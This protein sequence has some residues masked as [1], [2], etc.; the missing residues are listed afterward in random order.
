MNKK[1]EDSFKKRFLKD[2]IVPTTPVYEIYANA[3]QVLWDSFSEAYIL[4]PRS[5]ANVQVGKNRSVNFYENNKH[6]L[7]VAIGKTTTL[8]V[9]DDYLRSK[10]HITYNQDPS[11]RYRHTFSTFEECFDTLKQVL[12]NNN[13]DK[14]M[15]E[16]FDFSD[17]DVDY[18]IETEE[19]HKTTEMQYLVVCEDLD[20]YYES[21][22][23]MFLTL[24]EAKQWLR[25]KDPE[26]ADYVIYKV[27]IDKL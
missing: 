18:E 13:K 16:E 6:I 9:L 15:D 8:Y 10:I 26:F 27:K 21:A 1:D 5:I 4:R 19:L 24:E 3:A 20:G 12:N 22:M 23:E 7:E 11:G 14:I 25:E 17:I 2:D